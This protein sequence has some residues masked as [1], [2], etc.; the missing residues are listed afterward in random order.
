MRVVKLSK[1]L[2]IEL[3][4][5]VVDLT[6]SVTPSATTAGAMGTAGIGTGADI[7]VNV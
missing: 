4:R 5:A 3:N 2:L 1:Y 7:F 6:D